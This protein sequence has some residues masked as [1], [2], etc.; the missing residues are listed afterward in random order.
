MANYLRDE[1]AVLVECS[2]SLGRLNVNLTKFV[3][4]KGWLHFIGCGGSKISMVDELVIE[5][6]IF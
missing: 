2:N 1:G 6:V 5:D 4:M 3:H